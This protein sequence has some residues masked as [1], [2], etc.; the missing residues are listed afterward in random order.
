MYFKHIIGKQGE[1]IAEN[2]LK[3]LN[4]K[5][6]EKNFYCKQGEIDI[7][8]LDNKQIVFIEIKT[9]SNANYGLPSEAVTQ[10]KINSLY[11]TAEYFLYIRNLEKE[12]VRIDVI[13]IYMK[14]N[15]FKINHLKQVI[16]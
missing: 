10:K 1:E 14:D 16:W 15:K 7:I 13:E 11:K 2:Y 6:L 8:A 3:K 5:I 4:Y 12:D 9:R